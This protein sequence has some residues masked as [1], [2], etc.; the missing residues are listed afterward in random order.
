MVTPAKKKSSAEKKNSKSSSHKKKKSLKKI[1]SPYL[2]TEEDPDP[3]FSVTTGL[4]VP[5][6]A[7]QQRKSQKKD[8]TAVS[9]KEVAIGK[10]AILSLIAS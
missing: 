10:V 4:K 5:G 1:S 3:D 6:S 7:R 9:P 8:K 2:S